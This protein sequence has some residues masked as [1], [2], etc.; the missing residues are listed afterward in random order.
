ML[1]HLSICVKQLHQLCKP[2]VEII[3]GLVIA[4]L[5]R[6]IQDNLSDREM[7]FLH[8]FGQN[9]CTTSDIIVSLQSHFETIALRELLA[10]LSNSQSLKAAL[11]IINK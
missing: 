6:E 1:E 2:R 4:I 5:S 9:L 3:E 10:H 11:L 7:L 8:D